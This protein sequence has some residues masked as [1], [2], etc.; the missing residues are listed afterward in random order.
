M[1]L[2]IE[3]RIPQEKKVLFRATE[4]FLQN[5]KKTLFFDLFSKN[6]WKI[7]R[8]FWNSMEP[9]ET[10]R[11]DQRIFTV[12][13][14]WAFHELLQ[15]NIRI[16]TQLLAHTLI[17]MKWCHEK[18][19]RSLFQATE[20]FRWNFLE[21]KMKNPIFLFVKNFWKKFRIF[22]NGIESLEMARYNPKNIL[23]E[24]N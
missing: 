13:W 3:E 17:L 15:D 10:A 7:I 14:F 4:Q 20:Q 9:L 21:K 24:K 19:N 1:H 22:G 18:K 5:S 8:T 6:S 11:Y 23:A 16:L 12:H 2:D